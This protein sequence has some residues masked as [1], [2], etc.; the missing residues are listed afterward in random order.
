MQKERFDFSKNQARSFDKSL[1]QSN[2]IEDK[3]SPLVFIG[4]SLPKEEYFSVIMGT[5]AFRSM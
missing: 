4:V 3:E 1:T 2:T 5:E